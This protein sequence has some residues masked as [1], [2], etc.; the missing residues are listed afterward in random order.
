MSYSSAPIGVFDSGVGGIS[1]LKELFHLMPNENYIYLG[2]TKNA[3]YGSKTNDEVFKLSSDC[4]NELI[5]MGVKAVVIACNTA[6]SIAVNELRSKY[7]IP[8]IGIEPAVKPAVIAHPGGNVLVMATPVTLRN[9]KFLNLVNNYKKDAN[10]I[11]LPCPGLVEIIEKGKGHD[12]EL[13]EYLK[14]LF[15]P[16]GTLKIDV[17]VLGCTHYPHVRNQIAKAFEQDAEIIDGAPGTARE[18][19]RQLTE[20]GILN[21]PDKF[22]DIC[23]I[24]TL[25]NEKEIKIMKEFFENQ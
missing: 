5:A 25:Q 17:I 2:D 19:Q 4:V 23:F 21:S 10:I 1:V 6:T 7:S 22:G 24:S 13:S 12:S 20:L 11:P 8:I 16:Y 9:D 15:E 3:P 18:T 14:K